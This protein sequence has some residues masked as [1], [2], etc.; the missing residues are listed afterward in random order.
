MAKKKKI[1]EMIEI[2]KLFEIVKPLVAEGP[3]WRWNWDYSGRYE[4]GK[5]SIAEVA[6]QKY[7]FGSIP[8]TSV[9]L[10]EPIYL[11]DQPIITKDKLEFH[12]RVVI[13]LRIDID[14]Y[15]PLNVVSGNVSQFSWIPTII[16]SAHFIGQVTENTA[17]GDG[18]S[19]VVEEFTFT[20]PGT[21]EIIDRLNINLSPSLPSPDTP[22]AEVT[23]VTTGGREKGAYSLK[24]TSKYFH[25]VEIEVDRED[26]AIE[27]EPYNTYT[28]PN[29]PASVPDV[30]LTFDAAYRRAG[31]NITRAAE[32]TNILESDLAGVD[33]KWTELELHDAMEDHWTAFVNNPQWKMWVFLAE[34]AIDRDLAGVMFDG[35]IDEP[36][37]VDRQGTAVFTQCPALHNE[38][39]ADHTQG[40]EAVERELFTLMVHEAGHSFNLYHSWRKTAATPW[41]PP[42]WMPL[43]DDDLALSWMN[44]SFRASREATGSTSLNT[45]WFY[46]RFEFRFGDNDNMF[47]RHAPDRFVIMGGSDW[48]VDHGMVIRE[49]LDRRLELVLRSGKSC[50]ELGEPVT[51]E[52]RLK[53]I[54]KEN[55]FINNDFDL[56]SGGLDLAITG[57]Q[58]LRRPFLPF[59]RDDMVPEQQILK[60]GKAIYL[61]VNLVIGIGGCPFKEPGAY[62]IEASYQLPGGSATAAVMQLYIREPAS[63]EDLS[64]INELFNA[65]VGRLL[66]VGGSRVMEDALDRIQWV[67]GKLGKKHPAQFQIARALSMAYARPVK[68]IDIAN[69][70]IKLL[71]PD[72]ERA[73]RTLES[74]IARPDSAADSL[75]HI[76]Y[77][78]LVNA[79]VDCTAALP[80]K[81]QAPKALRDMLEMYKKRK[82]VKTVIDDT[83]KRLEKIK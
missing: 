7:P 8:P 53:N 72:P 71:E 77:T 29:R 35:H 67:G 17:T 48:G 62:R 60:P 68:I 64:I 31:I 22:T 57:P 56:Q 80:K 83:K 6:K 41:T 33:S 11:S 18:R 73:A 23:F 82:V 25:D 34:E 59:I 61:P 12:K 40:D 50:F 27:V 76:A 39:A 15:D 46:D 49:R 43:T 45:D 28:H 52:L 75:G 20:W 9:N 4:L 66:Y 1:T 16:S 51:I 14:R 10:K 55:V 24:R 78:K 38:F 36:G 70:K 42:P 79:Y 54:S 32:G 74:V 58:G 69:R 13:D 21:G 47:L 30:D 37:G 19:L 81:G 5:R 44:Y 65:R 2:E 3:F 26:G 63:M